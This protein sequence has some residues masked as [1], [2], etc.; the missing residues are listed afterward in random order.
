MA[1]YPN[2]SIEADTYTIDFEDSEVERICIEKWG[3]NGII[4]LNQ[5]QAVTTTNVGGQVFSGNTT[6]EKFNEF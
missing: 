3:S 2:L 4:T 6:I 1:Q 5:L